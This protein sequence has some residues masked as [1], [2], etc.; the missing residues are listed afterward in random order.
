MAMKRLRIISLYVHNFKGFEDETFHFEDYDAIIL[1]GMNGF[2]KTTIFDAVELLFTGKIARMEGYRGLHNNKLATSD[3]VLPLVC[4]MDSD[5]VSVEAQ[6]IIDDVTLHLKRKA[7]TRAMKNPVDFSAFGDLVLVENGN[8]KVMDEDK[9]SEIGLTSFI[10]DYSF[11]NYLSQEGATSF[12]LSKDGDRAK[13]I[14]NLF[15]LEIFDRPISLIDKVLVE[16]NSRKTRSETRIQDI[17][18]LMLTIN[19]NQEQTTAYKQICSSE[20]YWDKETPVLS[21]QQYN[22][23]L[24]Q[25]GILDGLSYFCEHYPSFVQHRRNI[26]V[27]KILESEKLL[28]ELVTY[29]KYK[30]KA[31]L[32]SMY[33]EFTGSIK[34][35][36]ESL[37]SLGASKLVLKLSNTIIS[38]ITEEHLAAFNAELKNFQTIYNMADKLHKQ[39]ATLYELRDRITD[40]LYRNTSL[41]SNG[42]CPLCG[43]KYTD[44]EELMTKIAE[45]IESTE[46]NISES[47]KLIEDQ[48]QKVKASMQNHIVKPMEELFAANGITQD[49]AAVYLPIDKTKAEKY[50]MTLE[51]KFGIKINDEGVVEDTVEALRSKIRAL[52]VK[53][54]D[55]LNYNIMDTTYNTFGRYLKEECISKKCIEE[56]RIYLALMYAQSDN[57]RQMKTELEHMNILAEKTTEA[58]KKLKS[59]KGELKTQRSSYL[60]KLLSDI[61]ILFYIYSGRIM[62]DCRFGRGLFVKENSTT[63]RI[64][65]TAGLSPNDEVDALYN[66]SSG[67]L[68]SIAIALKLSL[69]KLYSNT[70][71]LA[72]DDPVQTMDDLNLWGF[73]ETMRRDFRG[74]FLLLSTHEYDYESLLKYKFDKWN[75]KTRVIDMARRS[76]DL[77]QSDV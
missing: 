72:I 42:E 66:M 40:V 49:V 19:Q 29:V 26:Y 41:V 51:Q 69:N 17:K 50:I 35:V 59:M 6:V 10:N 75:I 52:V 13:V 37:D 61:K 20:Q 76:N 34:D 43:A 12:L 55:S 36:Y 33:A 54:D 67:Q 39:F 24:K 7:M 53:V 16:L 4:S 11:L 30:D 74:H 58:I 18:G 63:S 3:E 15:N 77:A 31:L 70:P 27:K 68:V 25:D 22:E 28:E 44:S 57:V 46:V 2:G 64:L 9:L 71:F 56:K 73:I 65:I 14:S 62:Q 1:G 48:L 8:E 60:T 32:I 23:L 5:T 47:Q 21:L 38:Y 45:H